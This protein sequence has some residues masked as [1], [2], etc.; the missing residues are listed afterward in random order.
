MMNYLEPYG[1]IR[2]KNK[3]VGKRGRED[4]DVIDNMDETRFQIDVK[5]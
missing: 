1:N 5:I 2:G 3:G 4:G